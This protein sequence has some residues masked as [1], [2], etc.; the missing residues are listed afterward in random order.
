VGHRT[1]F[2]FC[3]FSLLL[4]P[5][6]LFPQ[7]VDFNTP[8]NPQTIAEALVKAMSDED[9]L[10]QTFMFGW[11]GTSPSPQIMEWIRTR[12]IGGVKVFGWNTRN[13]ES[14]AES[15]GA[16][17]SASLAGPGKIPLLVATDQEGGMVRHVKDRTSDTP[18]NMAIGAAG[19]PEDAYKTGYYIGRELALLGINMNFAPVVDLATVRDSVLLGTRTFGEDP[20]Q[21]GI[22]GTAFMKGLLEAGIIGTA[23]HFPG[24]GGTSLDSHG[25]LPRIDADEKLL[26]ERELI[27]YRMLTRGGLPAIMSGHLAFPRTPA[28]N[29]PASLAPWFLKDILRNRIG[30][31]GMV[32]T[33]DLRMYGAFLTTGS[34]VLTARQALLAGN[35]MILISSTPA[36]NDELWINLL[37][38]MKSDSAFRVRVREAAKRV[39]ITKLTYLRGEKAAPL[40]PDI[41]RVRREIP[42]PEGQAFFQDLAARSVTVLKKGSLPLKPSEAGRVLL[43]GRYWNFIQTGRQAYRAAAVYSYEG[44]GNTAQLGNLAAAADTVIFC[45]ENREDLRLIESL[46]Y[47]NKRIVVFCLSSSPFRDEIGWVDSAA[48]LYSTS[49]KSFIAGFSVLLGRINEGAALP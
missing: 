28:G 6:L 35:D 4:L 21:V 49:E 24:H 22:L 30:F 13:L 26:W 7:I 38:L 8:G 1:F 9:A 36:L 33:D 45:L 41:G 29:E 10:S 20:V 16:M 2:P 31:Q 43:A 17:Q 37:G 11:T 40:V 19:F 42:D 34:L 46:R 48:A 27:P 44:M 12:H 32:I 39:L 3:F 14:L 18:G 23:K 47:L 5:S 15:I 25:T